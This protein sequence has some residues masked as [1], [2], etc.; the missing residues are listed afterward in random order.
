MSAANQQLIEQYSESSEKI[1]AQT[2]ANLFLEQLE[3]LHDSC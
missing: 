1:F 3:Q 2:A